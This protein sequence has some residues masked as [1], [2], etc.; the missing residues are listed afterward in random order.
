MNAPNGVRFA[1]VVVV[2]ASYALV[3]RTGEARVALQIADNVRTADRLRAA[4]TSL[5]RRPDLERE[6][7]RYAALE[8]AGGDARLAVARFVRD[9]ERAA[10]ARRSTIDAIAGAARDAA[11]TRLDLTID[12]RYADVLATVRALSR[13]SVPASIDVAS[14]ARKNAAARDT[15]VTA[16]VRAVLAPPASPTPAPANDASRQP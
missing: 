6:R 15:A 4:R 1:A 5:A 8:R 14:V 7:V 2:A 11:G 12:G 3:L 10:A 9:A 13:G 16:T